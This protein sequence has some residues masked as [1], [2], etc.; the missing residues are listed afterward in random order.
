MRESVYNS[1]HQTHLPK[2][3]ELGL[4]NYDRDRKYVEALD[5]SHHV[6]RYMSV[7]TR[8][9]ITWTEYYRA[10]GI[11]GLFAVVLA[12]SSLFGLDA[13]EPLV[14]ATTFLVLFAVSSAYQLWK[15]RWA[16]RRL[17]A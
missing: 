15:H 13:I 7:V 16:L 10:L 5:A 3:D 6:T 11:V 2:L 8:Y 9:G 1:L 4:V 17:V 12:E 14:P